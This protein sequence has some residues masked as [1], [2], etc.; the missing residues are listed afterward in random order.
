[1]FGNG[2]AGV[3]F[4]PDGQ[5]LATADGDGTV[6]LWDVAT[7]RQIGAPLTADRDHSVNPVLDSAAGV[8]FSPD[9]KIL[10][11]LGEDMT[12]RLWD[13]ATHR[14]IGSPMTT[15]PGP[16]SGS[17]PPIFEMAFSPSG[18]ILATAGGDGTL[19]LWNVATHR[20]IGAPLSAVS[21]PS[22]NFVTEVAFSP[23]GSSL[24]TAGWDGTVRLWDVA[25]GKQ[26]GSP[27]TDSADGQ[28][29]G[30][31]F[32]RDGSILATAGSA[33]TRLWSVTT[34]QQIGPPITVPSG[35]TAV[36]FN[37]D[38][39]VLT[40]AG[41]DG[42]TWLWTTPFQ[43]SDAELL[44]AVC[45]IADGSLSRARWNSYAQGEPYQVTCPG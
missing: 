1:V 7:H 20:L 32:S 9:G 19:L 11:T 15:G 40:T 14:Q 28:F 18:T 16:V 39:Q 43:V 33:G 36:A 38:G 25:T 44:R 12:I 17:F 29:T 22:S 30:V 37:P 45:A 4:S 23:D 27:I 8:A 13:V 31:A 41:Y 3:S 26:I 10:A 34:H 42:T 2:V 21:N 5:T 6:R 24:A 35:T